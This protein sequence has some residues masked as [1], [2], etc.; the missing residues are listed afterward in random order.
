M[1]KLSL[2]LLHLLLLRRCYVWLICIVCTKVI[3]LFQM[4][5]RKLRLYEA[6]TKI[7][8]INVII[9]IN[10]MNTQYL[11][12]I[13]IKFEIFYIENVAK[14]GNHSQV[15]EFSCGKAL[16]TLLKAPLCGFSSGNRKKSITL[17]LNNTRRMTLIHH[18]LMCV[19]VLVCVCVYE[20]KF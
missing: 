14:R 18:C 4:R 5:Y 6:I 15:R 16:E 11:K 9:L 13:I 20:Y 1:M 3:K 10:E 2:I 17:P 7:Q 12:L 8:T 19:Y